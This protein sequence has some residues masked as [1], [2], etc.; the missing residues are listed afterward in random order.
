[1]TAPVWFCDNCLDLLPHGH[2][3]YCPACSRVLEARWFDAQ[4][5]K[6]KP[7]DRVVYG[8]P[9][10]RWQS[11]YDGTVSALRDEDIDGLL[12]RATGPLVLVRA[13]D[14]LCPAGQ[15]P[16][17]ADHD[18]LKGFFLTQQVRPARGEVWQRIETRR[19]SYDNG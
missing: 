18:D 3:R 8:T 9:A 10:R 15:G 11:G 12:E 19:G 14:C 2:F 4:L 16:H 5:K 13:G 7:H 6:L 1:M 17:P